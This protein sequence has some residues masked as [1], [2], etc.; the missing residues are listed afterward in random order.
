MIYQDKA[1]ERISNALILGDVG[2]ALT[3][4][5]AYLMA[6]PQMQTQE[7]LQAIKKDYDLMVDYWCRGM[8]DPQQEQQYQLLL[9]RIYVLYANV[10]IYH[11]MKASAYL[12]G[13]YN[14]V[15]QSRKNWS[16]LDIRHEMEN[17]VSD[18]AMIE[19]EP[20]HQREERSDAIYKAHRQ[21]MN[22]LFNFVLT[23]RMWTDGVGRSFTDLLLSPTV[24]SI[25]QQLL[26]SAISLSQWMQFD[27]VKFRLLTEVYRRSHD[28]HVRQRALVGWVFGIEDDWMRVYPEQKETLDALMSSDAVCKELTELQIQLIF[29]ANADRDSDTLKNEIL[30]EM[31]KNNHFKVTKQGIQEVEDDPLEDVLHP[32]AEEERM[33]KTEAVFQR[34][35]DMQ[36]Q[37][38]DIYFGGFS[39]MKRYPFFYDTSNWLV[40]FYLRH[41]D[42]AQFRKKIGDNRYVESMMEHGPLCNS[43]KYSF[44]IVFLE[45]FERLPKSMRELLVNGEARLDKIETASDEEQRSPAYIRRIYLMDLYRLFRLFPN[46][47]SLNN[48]LE[49]IGTMDFFKNPLFSDTPL[50]PYKRDIVKVLRKYHYNEES[51]RLMDFFPESMRDVQYYMW[52]GMYSIALSMEPD[53]ERVMAAHARELFELGNYDEAADEYDKLMLLNPGKEKYILNKAVCLV[54]MYEYEDALKLLYQLNYEHPD[55]DFINR[56]MAWALTSDGKMEQGEQKYRQLIAG[57]TTIADDYQGLG[58]CLW[59]QNRINEAADSLRKFVEL[60]GHNM[61]EDD[62]FFELFDQQWAMRHGI[63]PIQIKM[64]ESLVRS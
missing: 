31:L 44:Y 37:G 16:V 25:D 46:R 43:D 28:E 2:K 38:S 10:S 40:P 48:T 50:D 39:Q 41:P 22:H 36:R 55:D 57:D 6:W 29:T 64:M 26:V 3:E 58:C 52:R 18:V 27:I 20:E 12:T 62:D 23:S 56:V 15:R 8:E 61:N 1:T 51:Q 21:E 60:S 11:R 42:L 7:R 14:T 45:M 30:P 49:S 33:E 32:E 4:M 19:L 35:M 54:N 24:D 34:M 59:L 17:Y 53:N 47:S 13:L 5:S 9:Q 63:T